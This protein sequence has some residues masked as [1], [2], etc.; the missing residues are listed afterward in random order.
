MV[1]TESELP[2]YILEIPADA[3]HNFKNKVG[4]R[5]FNL[6]VLYFAG[7]AVKKKSGDRMAQYVCKCVCGNFCIKNSGQLPTG[8]KAHQTASCGCK[9]IKVIKEDDVVERISRLERETPYKVVNQLT[10]GYDAKWIL[11]CPKHGNFKSRWYCVVIDG[12]KCPKCAAPSR[13]FNQ[14]IPGYFYINLL[15][16]E[17]GK[18]VAIKYGV[19]NST[20][21]KRR[22]WLGFGTSFNISTVYSRK[23]KL[24]ADALNL[25]TEFKRVFG[26]R[27]LT[28]EELEIGFTETTNPSNLK[29]CITLAVSYT[30]QGLN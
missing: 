19:T 9:R 22:T 8:R 6:E 13:G 30:P 4:E 26:T 18:P 5:V 20:P 21:D 15:E 16:D 27:Y 14:M 7:F 1:I 10:G 3:H 28:K 11:S 12:T 17:E 24:G 29:E 2:N 25:E 23:F